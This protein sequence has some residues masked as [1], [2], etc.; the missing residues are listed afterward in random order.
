MAD[1]INS[2]VF[3]G[4]AREVLEED[5]AQV[6]TFDVER[7]WKGDPPKRTVLYQLNTGES[8]KFLADARYV[9]GSVGDGRNS[10]TFQIRVPPNRGCPRRP[11]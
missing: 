8:I 1:P 4:T 2:V 7:V 9:G 6:V 5:T 10:G 3:N 11:A